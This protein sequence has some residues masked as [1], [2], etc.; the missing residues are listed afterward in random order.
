M[1]TR[2]VISMEQKGR[3]LRRFGIGGSRL[4]ALLALAVLLVTIQS[5]VLVS[6]TWNV[7]SRLGNGPSAVS[8]NL[9]L[10]SRIQEIQQRQTRVDQALERVMA[11]DAKLRRLTGN[12]SGAKA[13]G[14][15]PLSA[16]EVAAAERDGRTVTLPGEVFKSA[17]LGTSNLDELLDDMDLRSRELEQR[18]QRE[19]ESLAEVRGYL[20]DRTA[21]L[22][23]DPSI[24]PVRGWF[25]SAFG[26]RHNPV[27]GTEKLH[28]GIDIAAP[29]GTP[30]IAPADGHVVFAGWSASYGNLVVMDHGYGITT[31]YAHTSEMLVEV[32]DRVVRGRVIARVGSTGRSTGP[33]LH[34]EVHRRGAPVDP[35]QFLKNG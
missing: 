17:D 4:R 3:T 27:L 6:I 7:Y 19:E 15:G 24:W 12:D 22:R 14:I 10:R 9:L 5:L 16:L 33:H 29:R 1:Q 34:Y 30:V 23:A 2:V 26:W 18:V 13:F 32:G 31:K 8:E 35:L 28:A 11:Y 25:T 21:L 20:D